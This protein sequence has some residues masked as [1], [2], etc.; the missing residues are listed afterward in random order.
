MDP[1]PVLPA[2]PGDGVAD[3][4]YS[5]LVRADERDQRRNAHHRRAAE[6]RLQMKQEWVEQALTRDAAQGPAPRG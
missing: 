5:G 3:E 2:L 4:R 6:L 1:Q